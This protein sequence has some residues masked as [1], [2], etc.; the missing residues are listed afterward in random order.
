M[1]LLVHVSGRNQYYRCIDLTTRSIW[2]NPTIE[3]LNRFYSSSS[4]SAFTESSVSAGDSSWTAVLKVTTLCDFHGRSRRYKESL[5]LQT[6]VLPI[7]IAQSRHFS[8]P[9]KAYINAMFHIIHG[10][11]DAHPL[12]LLHLK[13]SVNGNLLQKLKLRNV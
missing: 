7:G 13:S 4:G 9:T 11:S 6:R 10:S 2:A 12:I 5:L 8:H 1:N 3:I